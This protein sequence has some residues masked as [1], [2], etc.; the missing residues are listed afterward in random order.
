MLNSFE[1]TPVLNK[2][3]FDTLI[4]CYHLLSSELSARVP[5]PLP[6]LRMKWCVP[7]LP[8]TLMRTPLPERT[9][10]TTT[11]RLPVTQSP[12]PK[13]KMKRTRRLFGWIGISQSS[14]SYVITPS[15]DMV[16]PMPTGGGYRVTELARS[17]ESCHRALLTVHLPSSG[18][19][20]FASCVL[21]A[22]LLAV[23]HVSCY[24]RHGSNLVSDHFCS[25]N[26]KG[27]Q[28]NGL[29]I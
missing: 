3:W 21:K 28:C 27:V 6:L 25:N 17:P 20:T 22:S 4:C 2:Y 23:C 1:F 24:N 16:R 9:T 15:P 13:R 7:P 11:M 14:H 12:T 18:P 19:K 10:T 8:R 26:P 5:L 29:S